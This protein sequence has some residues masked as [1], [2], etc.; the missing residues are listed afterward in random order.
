MV[1]LS[2]TEDEIDDVM[3]FF[4]YKRNDNRIIPF[5]DTDFSNSFGMTAVAFTPILEEDGK[6]LFN[7]FKLA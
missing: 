6:N 3:D 5:F 7:S 4:Y 2:A 1:C